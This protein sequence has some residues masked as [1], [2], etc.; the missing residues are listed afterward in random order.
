LPSVCGDRIQLQQVLLN[1]VINAIEAMSQTSEGLREIQ[2]SSQKVTEVAGVSNEST[3]Y[4]EASDQVDTAHVLVAVEDSGPGLDP[5]RVEQI[6]DA[7]YTTKPQGLGMGLAISR[8]IVEAHGGRLWASN[9]GQGSVF[10]FALPVRDGR[11]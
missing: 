1:L 9:T 2:V 11:K 4:C 6:F 3:L 8:S 10:R 5:R 7:F